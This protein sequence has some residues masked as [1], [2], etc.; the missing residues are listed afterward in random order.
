MKGRIC[1]FNLLYFE[2][3]FDAW[4]REENCRE[5]ELLDHFLTECTEDY[6]GQ[7]YLGIDQVTWKVK[8]YLTTRANAA[9]LS[10]LMGCHS[11]LCHSHHVG[12]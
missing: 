5:T 12:K 3:D 6:Y 4:D 2:L 10:V 7:D 1:P 9:Y 8:P 11:L